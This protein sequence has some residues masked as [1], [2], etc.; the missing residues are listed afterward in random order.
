MRSKNIPL[1]NKSPPDDCKEMIALNLMHSPVISFNF[2][3][4]VHELYRYLENTE[5][6][7]FPVLNGQGRPI[8]IV[9]R[10]AL[11]VLLKHKVWYRKYELRGGAPNF[12]GTETGD[13]I[14]VEEVEEEAKGILKTDGVM[15]TDGTK[16]STTK[17]S[18]KKI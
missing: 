12:G 4:P 1:L 10:D 7:G 5:H 14:V 17:K 6:C 8:G 18:A 11:I 2:I 9:E 13:R 15:K 3:S 16:R